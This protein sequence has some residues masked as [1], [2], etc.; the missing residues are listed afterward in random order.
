MIQLLNEVREL[1]IGSHVL[2]PFF[3]RLFGRLPPLIGFDK[4]LF[5]ALPYGF[6]HLLSEVIDIAFF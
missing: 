1:N 4:P 2:S 5:D 3:D 6:R